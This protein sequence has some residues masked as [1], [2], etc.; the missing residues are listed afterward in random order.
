VALAAAVGAGSPALAYDDY[1]FTAAVMGGLG[2]SLDVARE[3]PFDA[4]ALQIAFGMLTQERTF[5]VLR[6]GRLEFDRDHLFAGRF[7]NEVEYVN[8][9]GEYRFRQPSYDLGLF[10]GVGDYR[11]SGSPVGDAQAE[12][13]VLGFT[14]GVTGDFDVTRRLS[15]VAE[16]D[17][18][19]ALFDDANLYGAALAG[20]AVHF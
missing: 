18:H 14:L 19:Y 3:D 6:A 10:L 2:G 7:G 1:T 13:E 20:L 4:S 15:F 17:L 5:V 16:L 9:A 11:A 8:V 12:E